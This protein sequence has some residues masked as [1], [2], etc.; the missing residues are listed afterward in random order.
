MRL[1]RLLGADLAHVGAQAQQH[2]VRDL[3]DDFAGAFVDRLEDNVARFRVD[4]DL[5][6]Q[7]LC[8]RLDGGAGSGAA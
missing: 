1:S 2:L 4:D 6:P 3:A 5:L 7:V 8:R